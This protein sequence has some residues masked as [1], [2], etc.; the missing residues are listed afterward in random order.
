MDELLKQFIAVAKGR[1]GPEALNITGELTPEQANQIISLVVASTFLSKVNTVR[2]MR[3]TRH[4]NAMDVASRQLKRIAQGSEP[5]EG[6]LTKLLGAGAELMALPVQLF[7]DVTLDFI[8]DILD[9]AFNGEKDDNSDGFLTLNKGWVQLAK[10]GREA[11][12]N[13]DD[14][15]RVRGTDIDP[16]TD[17]WKETLAAVM[18]AGDERFR[19]NSVF[20]MNLADADD[21]ARELGAHVTGTPLTAESPLRRFE[22]YAIEAEPEMPRGH[23][24]FTPLKNLAFGLHSNIRRDRAYHAR[25]RALEYTFDTACDFEIVVGRAMSVGL[26]A[27]AGG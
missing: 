14:P 7:A 21:Y 8:R 20:T 16:A 5:A 6:D 4:V 26:P 3:L 2:M 23:V 10:E 13:D 18:N 27:A 12:E 24:F 9:L 19:R 11:G 22:G 1:I 15:K 25:K 17:G